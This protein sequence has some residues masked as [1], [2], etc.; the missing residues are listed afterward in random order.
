M[1]GLIVKESTG[2]VILHLPKFIYGSDEWSDN[3]FSW[4]FSCFL[5]IH[6][7]ICLCIYA[8]IHPAI[9]LPTNYPFIYLSIYQFILTMC[10]SLNLPKELCGSEYRPHV[11]VSLSIDTSYLSSFIYIYVLIDVYT[12]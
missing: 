2:Q 8:W 9:Y 5:S 10:P 4:S 6:L 1:Y 7:Y 3:Y 11:S 12:N